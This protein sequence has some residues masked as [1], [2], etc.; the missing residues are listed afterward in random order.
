MLRD[1]VGPGLRGLGFAGSGNA[2]ALRT[3]GFSRDHALLGVRSWRYNDAALTRFTLNVSF[4]G[5]EDWDTAQAT[6]KR[7]GLRPQAKPS[8][9]EEYF[10]GWSERI[11]FLYEP[12]HDHWWAVQNA[13]DAQLVAADVIHVVKTYALP[14][15]TARLG[16]IAMSTTTTWMTTRAPNSEERILEIGQGQ[17]PQIG[18]TARGL[19]H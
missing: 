16:R 7:L 9:N 2:F 3:D 12:G 8:P 17:Y 11:G 4:Y 10:C 13:A 19:R 14:Q 1:K 6:A 5:A 15:L 18:I